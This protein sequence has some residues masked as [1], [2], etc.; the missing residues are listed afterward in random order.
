MVRFLRKSWL[1]LAIIICAAALVPVTLGLIN[2]ND[3]GYLSIGI[4]IFMA[5]IL[6]ALI[7]LLLV[8]ASSYSKKGTRNPNA[9]SRSQQ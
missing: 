7:C 1:I 5:G 6:F 2:N 3:K 4:G 8:G 9:K